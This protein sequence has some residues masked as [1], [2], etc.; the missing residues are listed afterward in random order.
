MTWGVICMS[1]LTLELEHELKSGYIEMSDIN[2]S[3]AN[4]YHSIECEAEYCNDEYLLYCDKDG[5]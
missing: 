1:E 3:I 5:E 2:L 4:E